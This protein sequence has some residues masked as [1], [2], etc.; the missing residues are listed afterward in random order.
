MHCHKIRRHGQLLAAF[1]ALL[2]TLGSSGAPA[3]VEQ[4]PDGAR[5]IEEARP[6]TIKATEF[7]PGQTGR[8]LRLDSLQV[9]P[10]SSPARLV[11]VPGGFSLE[12]EDNFI[13]HSPLPLFSVGLAGV[14]APGQTGKLEVSLVQ[15]GDGAGSIIHTQTVTITGSDPAALCH[16]WSDTAFNEIRITAK[17]DI[18]VVWTKILTGCI[19]RLKQA[20][21]FAEPNAASASSEFIRRSL[22]TGASGPLGVKPPN[23]TASA[24]GGPAIA[25]AALAWTASGPFHHYGSLGFSGVDGASLKI[26]DT[27]LS[28]PALA[29]ADYARTLGLLAGS[30][31]S[32]DGPEHLD[33]CSAVPVTAFGFWLV[34]PSGPPALLGSGAFHESKF[35][36]RLFHGSRQIGT[37][38]E[39]SPLN[40][41][42]A[43]WGVLSPQPFTRIEIREDKGG[44][45]ENEFF[46]QFYTTPCSGCCGEKTA[47]K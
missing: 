26:G 44:E 34:E 23:L 33:V 8:I 2:P 14:I 39:F 9:A 7:S 42:R 40:D 35:T 31:L 28:L 27:H 17:S 11:I 29:S 47:S 21:I 37:T 32:P 15:R 45:K 16:F 18:P 46:G 19:P 41:Q 10:E 30:E 20:A 6:C 43:F 38:H 5:F 3:I 13:I 12:G 24:P 1:T 22:A 36:I 4:M 25:D